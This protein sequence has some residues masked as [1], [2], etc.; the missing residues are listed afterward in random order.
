MTLDSKLSFKTYQQLNKQLINIYK[1]RYK[2]FK[3]GIFNVQNRRVREL[4]KCFL[5]IQKSTNEPQVNTNQT[6]HR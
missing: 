2:Y 6:D 5:A 3:S 1:A 4:L